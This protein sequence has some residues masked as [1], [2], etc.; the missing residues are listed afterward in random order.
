MMNEEQFNEQ[1]LVSESLR[2]ELVLKSDLN[3]LMDIKD[4]EFRA[5]AVSERRDTR[6]ALDVFQQTS[7][8]NCKNRIEQIKPHRERKRRENQAAIDLEK[9]VVKPFVDME[10]KAKKRNY[11]LEVIEKSIAYEA[12]RIAQDA[13]NKA[14]EEVR[15]AQAVQT[16]QI[17]GSEAAEAILDAPV[18]PV[19]AVEQ[20][21]PEHTSGTSTRWR[22]KIVDF[23]ALCLA[24][25][26]GRAPIEFDGDQLKKFVTIAKLGPMAVSLKGNMS[27]VYPGCVAESFTAGI[28]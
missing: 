21:K 2:M 14:A 19:V 3:S 20:A 1:E 25:G 10:K 23:K 18:A 11:E 6:K 12:N 26:E 13:A 27:S 22:A 15:L 4:A 28:E 9:R 24:I 17:H 16:E 8:L 7:R 5:L